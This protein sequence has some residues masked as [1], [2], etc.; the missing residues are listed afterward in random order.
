MAVD[1]N[2]LSVAELNA[3]VDQAKARIEQVKKQ[4][5]SELRRTL[6]AQAREAGFDI[7]DLFTARSGK[8]VSSSGSG[9]SSGDAASKRAVAPK[10]CNPDDKSK[11]WTGRGKRP[12]WVRDALAKGA[13]LDSLAIK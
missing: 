3:L 4:Q 9:S 6:E 11:T 8:S 10:Y 13:D 12:H 2:G 7:Y 1:L 5:Y